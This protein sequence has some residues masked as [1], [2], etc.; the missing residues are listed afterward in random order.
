[1]R[2]TTDIPLPSSFYSRGVSAPA[3]TINP[4]SV[5]KDDG[6]GGGGGGGGFPAQYPASD[7]ALRQ[8]KKSWTEKSVCFLWV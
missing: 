1:M 3:T 4:G 6:G 2:Q 8:G 5:Q 7:A